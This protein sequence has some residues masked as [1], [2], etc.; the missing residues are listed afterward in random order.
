M[1]KILIYFLLFVLLVPVQAL[2]LSYFSVFG[3]V[4]DLAF[5]AIYLIGIRFGEMEG[6]LMGMSL[7]FLLDFFSIGFLGI[8]FLLRSAMGLASGVLGRAFLDMS[9]PMTFGIVFLGCLFQDL[10]AYL[11]LNLVSELEGFS[12]LFAR[13]LLPRAFYTAVVAAVVFRFLVR[14]SKRGGMEFGEKVLFT[15]GRSS[16]TSR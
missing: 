5:V 16:G 11:L 6:V 14:R 3:T 1:K 7:G 15:P 2:L 9:L 13:S 12:S 8:N 10:A 4:P